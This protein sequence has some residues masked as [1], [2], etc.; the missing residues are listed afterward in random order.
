MKNKIF[1]AGSINADLVVK[2]ERMPR[3]GETL[4]GDWFKIIPGGKGA[5][6][7]VAAARAGGDVVFS[8][9]IGNDDFG[10]FVKD[11][12]LENGLS[13]EYLINDH[14]NPTG[15]AFITVDGKGEN[16]IIIIGGAN[17]GWTKNDIEI[18]DPLWDEVKIMLLNFEIPLFI[19]SLLIKKAKENGVTVIIDAG[20]IRNCP[21][22]LYPLID[23][24]SPNET[25]AETLTGIKIADL[26]SA[27]KA[28]KVLLRKGCRYAVMKLGKKGAL[29]VG[30]EKICHIPAYKLEAVD[31]TAAGDAFTGA[32][33]SALLNSEKLGDACLFANAAGA[34]SVTKTGAQPSLPYKKEIDAFLTAQNKNR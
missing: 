11:S 22:N 24:F 19:I 4:Q 6:Q 31:T 18:F 28:G 21:E 23:I 26:N 10:K 15:T 16:S 29:I 34:L 33:A 32:L 30:S 27:E 20:A 7:A 17:T 13:T 25:E 12:I 8:A 3:P 5:N 2:T 1:I 14:Q 9:R